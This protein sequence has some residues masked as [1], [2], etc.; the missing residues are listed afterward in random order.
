MRIRKAVGV[1]W[2]GRRPHNED[3]LIRIDTLPLYG[4]ADGMGG[5]GAGEV[6]AAIAVEVVRRNATELEARNRAV[7]TRRSSQNRLALG[8][9]LDEVFNGASREIQKEAAR[10]G[11]PGMAATLLIATVVGNFAYVA[12]VGDCRA[13]LHRAGRLLRLTEDHSVA[14]FRF[15]RGRISHEEYLRSPDRRVLYQVL[16]TGMEVDVDLAEVRLAGGDALLLCT[17]GLPRALDEEA[18][19]SGI[20]LSDLSGS[21]RRL[22]EMADEAGAPDN[23]SVILLGV[24]AEVGDEPIEAVTDVMSKVFLFETLSQPERLVVAP[25]LEEMV[26]EAED[27]VVREGEPADAFYVVLSGKVRVTRGSTVLREIRAGGHF[28]EMALARSRT[29]SATVR[30]VGPTR[31]FSLSRERFHDVVRARPDLGVRLTLRLLDEVGERLRD[32]TDRLNA[33]ERAARGELK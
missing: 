18:I 24:D 23:V 32:L 13:Y 30:A 7:A 16:G 17:D 12:H 8:E 22:V 5:P 21:A 29:R 9:L 15:R 1:C 3:A 26:Y 10:L 11:Q 19:A 14:E 28:G 4:L 33:V 31:V 6:A 2:A 25:Y 20:D 27:V